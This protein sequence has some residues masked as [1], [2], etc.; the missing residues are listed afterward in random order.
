MDWRDSSV[1]L[2]VLVTTV[3]APVTDDT[4]QLLAL[5]PGS[6]YR[7]GL[8]LQTQWRGPS[9]CLSVVTGDACQLLVL[10]SGLFDRYIKGK[11][12]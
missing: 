3:W 8:L 10:S 2:Y 11:R 9:V 6:W 7:C 12:P 4:C 1:C 5:S